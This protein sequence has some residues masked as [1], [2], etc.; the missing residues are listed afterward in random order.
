MHIAS[1]LPQKVAFRSQVVPY[2]LFTAK[3]NAEGRMYTTNIIKNQAHT[4][5]HPVLQ[6][7]EICMGP[8]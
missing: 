7:L 3:F 8:V 5:A 2:P 4:T 1:I 6:F